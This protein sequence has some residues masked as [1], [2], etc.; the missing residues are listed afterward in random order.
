MTTTNEIA[1]KIASEQNLTFAPGKAI[2]DA[3]N[4]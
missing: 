4:A 3:L 2:K 1:D